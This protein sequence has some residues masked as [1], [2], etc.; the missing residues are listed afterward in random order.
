MTLGDLAT[1]TPD[2]GAGNGEG[3]AFRESLQRALARAPDLG[4]PTIIGLER[5]TL[6][7]WSSYRAELI[8]LRLSAGRELR[9]FLKDY[10]ACKRVK[11]D[12][13]RAGD[14]V[15]RRWRELRVY[16]DVLATANLGTPRYYGA[17]WDDSR[18]WFWLLL[19][20]V[21]GRKLKEFKFEHWLEAARWLGRM[22]G[23]FARVPL[24]GMD[25]LVEHNGTFFSAIAD[26]AV[27]AAE[28]IS[29]RLAASL[30]STLLSYDELIPMMSADRS[31]LVHGAYR[32]YNIVVRREA[33]HSVCALDWEES[34][35]GSPIYDLACLADG[36]ERKPPLLDALIEGYEQEAAACGLAL[37][38]RGRLQR[39]IYAFAM[40]RN[41]KT[42]TKA[43]TRRFTLE[44]VNALVDRV[45]QLARRVW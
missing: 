4:A 35:L 28:A 23:H 6:T 26:D 7:S 13:L 36:F 20:Y 38:D 37:P 9:L 18:R 19:E 12:A 14:M 30:G 44:G 39:L 11:E 1:E 2:L 22:Q 21:E 10:G 33:H 5:T 24:S 42:L 41:L 8:T 25:F 43:Q 15:D 31:V 27:R 40:H 34:A 3:V 32:P 29:T 17:V 45:Q 16:R